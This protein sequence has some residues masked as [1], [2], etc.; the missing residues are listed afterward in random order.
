M[1]APAAKAK[2]DNVMF[3]KNAP[4]VDGAANDDV[5]KEGDWHEMTS[6]MWG[7]A[8]EPSDFSGRY[9]LR[10]NKDALYLLVRRKSKYP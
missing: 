9:K 4:V 3:T 5:W 8:P 7:T 2:S 6:L 10:W 1:L